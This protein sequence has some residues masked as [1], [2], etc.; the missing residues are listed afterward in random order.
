MTQ[1]VRSGGAVRQGH[2]PRA[3]L[4]DAGAQA[5]LDAILLEDLGRVLVRLLRERAQDGMPVVDHDHPGGAHREVA[6]L[7]RERAVD[8]L[9][10]RARD[11]RAGRARAHDDEG[12]RPLVDERRV[13]VGVLER[14][15]DARPEAL[16]VGQ[17]VE[18]EGVL[19]CAR[20][21]EEVGLGA[22]RE[23]QVVARVGLT[24]R[25]WSPCAWPGRRSPRRPASRRRW[26]A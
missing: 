14:G 9:R 11:L 23:H 26:G 2:V 5:Q 8:H 18:R 20:R 19:G 1:R 12:E 3:D 13:A 16:C 24:R 21:A 25:R 4:G 6:E 10:E 22:T 7:R 15:D 17:G